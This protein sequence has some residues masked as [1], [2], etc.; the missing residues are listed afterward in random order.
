MKRKISALIIGILILLSALLL[1]GLTFGGDTMLD[2]NNKITFE[3][4][5]DVP[6]EYWD[7]LSQKRIFFGHQ[8]VGYDII[9]GIEQLAREYDYIR[10]NIVE[11][12]DPGSQP[13]AILAHARVGRNQDSASK[14]TDFQAVLGSGPDGAID[15]AILKFCY[16]DI[17]DDVAPEDV[18]LRYKETIEGLK[19]Q[20]GRTEFLHFTVPL[21]SKPIKI[22][23]RLH[24]QQKFFLNK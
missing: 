20:H 23:N 19:R 1:L 12:S 17:M 9:A 16:V 15:I 10:L 3:S 14:L 6:Q 21:C 24:H 22:K 7:K 18:F 11:T 8:S 5:D 4:L 2:K 13:G